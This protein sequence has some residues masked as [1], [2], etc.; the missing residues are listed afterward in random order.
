MFRVLDKH[1]E[2]HFNLLYKHFN[3]YE[4]SPIGLK[5]PLESL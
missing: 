1:Q 4:Y 5:I 2:S 3:F